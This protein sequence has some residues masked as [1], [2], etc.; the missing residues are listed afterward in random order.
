MFASCFTPCAIAGDT[1]QRIVSQLD[2]YHR[3][4]S[5]ALLECRKQ[6]IDCIKE[7]SKPFLRSKPSYTFL[8][9]LF[10]NPQNYSK[11]IVKKDWLKEQ[12]ILHTYSWPQKWSKPAICNL[13][14]NKELIE[15]TVEYLLQKTAKEQAGAMIIIESQWFIKKTNLDLKRSEG[16]FFDYLGV[17]FIYSDKNQW[18]M[19][20][21]DP[22]FH[23]VAH[24]AGVLKESRPCAISKWQ[25]HA[26][27]Q[28]RRQ[29]A[30]KESDIISF[31]VNLL[32]DSCFSGP[33]Q[34]D[35]LKKQ[36]Q[37]WRYLFHQSLLLTLRKKVN[38]SS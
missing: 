36:I 15:C 4:P 29:Y 20:P 28:I 6:L 1:I 32:G 12:I 23:A 16:F 38:M 18:T 8:N 11:Q 7:L 9:P 3:P 31:H 14:F 10:S 37:K 5:F 17:R 13:L 26:Q 34:Q 24:E 33:G 35:F 27:F 2:R 22:S 19:K 30:K 21:H 25:N